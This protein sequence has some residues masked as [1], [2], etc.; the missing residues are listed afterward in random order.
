MEVFAKSRQF[1]RRRGCRARR[2][3]W[4]RPAA[5]VPI[6]LLHNIK[7]NKVLHERVVILTVAIQDVPYVDP[8]NA[9]RTARIWARASTG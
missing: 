1:Q 3:S 6:A 4:P 9:L 5:G 8:T 2:S 7:H